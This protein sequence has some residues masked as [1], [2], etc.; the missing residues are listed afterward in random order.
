MLAYCELFDVLDAEEFVDAIQMIEQ[1]LLDLQ[2]QTS[3]RADRYT[4]GSS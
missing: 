3:V 4:P 2:E 1:T